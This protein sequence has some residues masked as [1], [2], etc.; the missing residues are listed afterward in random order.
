MMPS[1]ILAS[2]SRLGSNLLL[3][4]Q[5]VAELALWAA[6]TAALISL[7]LQSHTAVSSASEE[8]SSMATH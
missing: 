8:E 4:L 1:M 6:S 5:L 7:K 2:F 3:S